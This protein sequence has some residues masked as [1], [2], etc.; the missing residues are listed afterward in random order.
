M[1]RP[2]A[3]L[4]LLR[5]AAAARVQA[6]TGRPRF[7]LGS[8]GRL[9]HLVLLLAL[10]VRP[11]AGH[12]DFRLRNYKSVDSLPATNFTK[13][14]YFEHLARQYGMV[15]GWQTDAVRGLC[16]QAADGKR[17][18]HPTCLRS[19]ANSY[20]YVH[21]VGDSLI[22]EL[23][24]SFSRAATDAGPGDDIGG[25][26]GKERPR[27][28]HGELSHERFGDT[29]H[30]P[31]FTCS[32]DAGSSS[33]A[34]ATLCP[35]AAQREADKSAFLATCCRPGEFG[36]LFTPAPYIGSPPTAAY[37]AYPEWYNEST[38][39]VNEVQDRCPCRGL[40]VVNV[41]MHLL[42]PS[43]R[44]I[45]LDV[46]SATPQAWSF[47]WGGSAGWAEFFGA[48]SQPGGRLTPVLA[49]TP[50]PDVGTMLRSPVKGD[51]A[52]FMP[53]GL[54][55]DWNALYKQ[56]AAELGVG[57]LPWGE[58]TQSFPG[59]TCDGIHHGNAPDREKWGCAGFSVVTDLALQSLLAL[60]CAP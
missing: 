44:E 11:A 14:F 19:L 32:L 12:S 3:P 2:P 37:V 23:A 35:A 1:L 16:P 39:V 40:L 7:S 56:T 33:G 5:G 18:L 42:M 46:D 58:I 31:S 36:M 53:L 54:L 55:R 26:T 9:W 20:D 51:W 60:V 57:Y 17:L 43:T 22:R 30:N 50:I 47:P 21:F 4:S 45:S 13:A 8:C 41:A 59:L 27:C 48:I 49:S 10:F 24:W 34:A 6:T 29:F 38:A 28:Q 52:S 15:S 25:G